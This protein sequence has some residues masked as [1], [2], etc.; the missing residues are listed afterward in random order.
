M[1]KLLETLVG[2]NS[3]KDR[4]G[5]VD[6]TIATER[7]AVE[8]LLDWPVLKRLTIRLERPNPTDYQDELAVFNHLNAIGAK[9]EKRSYVAADDRT[10][11]RPDTEMRQLAVVAADNGEVEVTGSDHQGKRRTANSQDYRWSLKRFYD[12]SRE[13][14]VEALL[15]TV[16]DLF[17]HRL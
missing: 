10:T 11:I 8:K 2:F 17:T 15:R 16:N 6:L 4:F 7:E 1:Y 13:T 14:L 12:H 3:I 9:I 5:K